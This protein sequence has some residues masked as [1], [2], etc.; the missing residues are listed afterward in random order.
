MNLGLLALRLV[1][2][3]LFAGHGA[4]KLFGAFG[5]SGIEGTAAGFEKGGLRPARA[6]AWIAG[7]SELGGGLL[8]ALG[9]LTPFAAAAII[10]V[11]TA[12][13]VGVHA[14]KGV[15]NT[16]GGYEYNLVLIAAAFGLAATGAGAWSLDGVL[17]LNLAGAGW[18]VAALAA[19]VL[20]GGTAVLLGRRQPSTRSRRPRPHHHHAGAH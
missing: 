17:D 13:I 2:G 6:H 9:L 8:L 12:A 4:Q 11:M 1:V 18:A 5:G 15:W 3:L 14:P 7:L 10:A 20:G 19:G 16:A